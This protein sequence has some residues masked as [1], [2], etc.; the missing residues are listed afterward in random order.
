[1][2]AKDGSE[3]DSRRSVRSGEGRM[4]IC[5]LRDDGRTG[6]ILSESFRSKLG[7]ERKASY[8]QKCMG[9]VRATTR[10]Q[11]KHFLLWLQR[12]F[13]LHTVRNIYSTS[14]IQRILFTGLSVISL[15]LKRGREGVR[16][17]RR[18]V[19]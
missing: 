15:Q 14:G 13:I 17:Y 9:G 12:Q 8:P 11:C 5:G 2:L 18:Q 6:T 10:L 7:S 19:I 4:Q 3:E 16:H 1:M